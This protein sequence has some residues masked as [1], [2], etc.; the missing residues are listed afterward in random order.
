V[1][2]SRQDSLRKESGSVVDQEEVYRAHRARIVGL[3]RLLLRDPDEAED[4]AQ[5]V[6]MRASQ[7]LRA[8]EPPAVWEAW[9]VRVAVNAC[10]DRR[11]SWWWKNR[12]KREEFDEAAAGS[13]P[14]SP[15]S[16]AEALT[17]EMLA[18]VWRRMRQLKDK[19]REVF[20]LRY[21]EGWSTAEVAKA[22]GLSTAGVK[23]HLFRAVRGLRKALEPES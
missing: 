19:Q 20:V 9:L 10:H 2:L 4:V 21:V 15:S 7:Y 8:H 13:V 11:R 23:T 5:E 22:M 1:F 17:R 14:S 16:E 18:R 3:C 12:W 6:F